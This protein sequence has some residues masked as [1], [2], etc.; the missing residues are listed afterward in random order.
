MKPALKVLLLSGCCLLALYGTALGQDGTAPQPDDEFNLFLFVLLFCTILGACVL[1]AIGLLLV[2]GILC[3]LTA[4][5][6]FTVSAL[7]AWRKRSL[8]AGFRAF[9][10]TALALGGGIAGALLL[11]LLRAWDLLPGNPK[12]LAVVGFAAG[13]LGGLLMGWAALRLLRW[14]L[15]LAQ[16]RFAVARAN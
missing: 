1:V 9:V 3:A 14:G 7:T 2:V 10:R 4:A 5:G 11:F 8:G 15:K 13:V 6:A 12:T 16:E